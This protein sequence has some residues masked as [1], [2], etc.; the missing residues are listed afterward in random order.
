MTKDDLAV[1]NTW[2]NTN[3]AKHLANDIEI[4]TN[5]RY[6]RDH[7][8]RVRD[9][10]LFLGRSLNLNPQQLLIAE[11][12]G[13]LHDAGRFAQFAKYRTFKDYKTEDHAELG[14][15]V[16][17]EQHVLDN[18]TEPERQTI[19]VAIRNHNKR[20]IAPSVYGDNLLFCQLIR[21]ADKLD[22]LDQIVTF[23]EKPELT[24]YFAV[25]DY[26]KT[27]KYSDDI[28]EAIL[29]N[30]QISYSAVKSDVD[31]KIVRM[32]W[33]LDIN[34]PAAVG[35]I[36]DKHYLD[37]IADILPKTAE[38]AR[39]YNYIKQRLENFSVQLEVH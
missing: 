4:D 27:G 28:I 16:L 8:F 15:T 32:S 12:I 23:Y 36:K 31:M 10:I 22:I 29:N 35:V 7:S 19:L 24:P 17:T 6:K 37:R 33:L 1:F 38:T 34:F 26:P 11:A 14:L 20:T 9:N 39:V 30:R 21:D 18:L 13:L 25:E 2:F 3:F 5:L